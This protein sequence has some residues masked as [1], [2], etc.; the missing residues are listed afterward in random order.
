MVE[1]VERAQRPRFISPNASPARRPRRRPRRRCMRSCARRWPPS[2]AQPVAGTGS[3][4]ASST[5]SSSTPPTQR[6]SPSFV[7]ALPADVICLAGVW[8]RARVC[9]P[10]S[11]L[12][13]HRPGS[14]R[15]RR[16]STRAGDA[17]ARPASGSPRRAPGRRTPGRPRPA[18]AE[19][20][21]A[22]CLALGEQLRRWHSTRGSA[23]FSSTAFARPR[24]PGGPDQRRPL[25][26]LPR[27]R[28]WLAWA[29]LHGAGAPPPAPASACP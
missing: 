24:V 25:P 4:S 14:G 17:G 27:Y 12:R 3:S 1:P 18:G 8:S 26:P 11:R 2:S 20:E 29:R 23:P 9:P 16:R 15:S 13:R 5:T 10:R 19:D 28:L 6:A 22:G 7:A 21:R